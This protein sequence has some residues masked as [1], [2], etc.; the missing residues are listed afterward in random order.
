MDQSEPQSLSSLAHTV[1]AALEKHERE[2]ADR[3]ITV[4]A[5]VAKFASWYE[6][7]RNAMDYREEEVILR[8][9][10]ERNLKRRI[11]LGGSG[12][13]VAEPLLRELVWARYFPNESLSE[14]LIA[15]VEEKV[16]LYLAL[17]KSI[18]SQKKLSEE[19]VNEWIFH[20]MSSDLEYMLNPRREEDIISNFMF[21]IFKNN[22]VISDDTKQTRDAQVYIAVRKS[23]AKDDLAFLRY[24]LFT[25]LF[26]SLTKQ[27]LETITAS[28]FDGYKE[29]QQQLTYPRKERIYR[30]VKNRTPIF[31]IFEDLITQQKANFRTLIQNKD[32]FKTIVLSACNER[33]KTIATKVKTAI[34]RSFVFILLTKVFFAFAIEGTYDNIVYGHILWGSLILN[35][36]TPPLLLIVVSLFIRAP[37]EGNSLRIFSYLQEVIYDEKPAL[38][39][40]LAVK[41]TRDKSQP[42]L[43]GIFTILWLLAF[44]ISFGG[45]IFILTKLHFNIVSQGV[46]IFFLAIVSFL[47]YRI[48]IS[49]REFTVED[50]QG[51]G[52]LIVDF[53]FMPIIRVGRHLTEGISQI[54]IFLFIFDFVIETPFKGIFAFFEQWFFFLH[55]KREEF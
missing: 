41:K 51:I 18:I 15:K 13:T 22:I 9:A 45:L 52:T 48:G 36:V 55:A 21:H 46:F 30:Y 35:M 25:Q 4:N 1:I 39:Q 54:N 6:K 11:L 50:R 2:V 12:K 31:F 49:S 38:G 24:H 34:I 14:S 17:R 47:C 42:V 10:I 5:V 37:G 40:P 3:K 16:D 32:E 26:G 53:L 27:S 7:F 44:I 28:F 33:Y 20:L 23:F 43:Y 19:A 29:I 8:A